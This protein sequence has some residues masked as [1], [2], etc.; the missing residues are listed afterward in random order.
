[1]IIIFVSKA[2]SQCGDELCGLA[3]SCKPPEG[4][5][6]PHLRKVAMT[7]KASPGLDHLIPKLALSPH[8]ACSSSA[9]VL[10]LTM[11]KWKV[12]LHIAYYLQISST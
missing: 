6:F 7:V 11:N 3:F 12:M 4:K 5:G 10:K 8:P 9:R 2:V 1:M